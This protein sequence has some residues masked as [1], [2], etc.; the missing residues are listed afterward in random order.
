MKE[1]GP[2]LAAGMSFGES[3]CRSIT[4]P[5]G[6]KIGDQV[7]K[8]VEVYGM[9]NALFSAINNIWTKDIFKA[10]GE[11]P[12]K[13]LHWV[14]TKRNVGP[15]TLDNICHRSYWHTSPSY[16]F[17][18]PDGKNVDVSYR[19]FWNR[20]YAEEQSYILVGLNR[21]GSAASNYAV[22]KYVAQYT[23][24]AEARW[25][26]E[27]EKNPNIENYFNHVQKSFEPQLACASPIEMFF[28]GVLPK[29]LRDTLDEQQFVEV[30]RAL[31]NNGHDRQMADI[32]EGA[33]YIIKA[34]ETRGT[35]YEKAVGYREKAKAKI[36][37][38]LGC[39]L[40]NQRPLDAS[41]EKSAAEF[42]TQLA[43]A[44]PARQRN[45]PSNIGILNRLNDLLGRLQSGIAC[46]LPSQ[47]TAVNSVST[48]LEQRVED[49]DRRKLVDW[50]IGQ[51]YDFPPRGQKTPED[52]INKEPK[53]THVLNDAKTDCVPCSSKDP[54]K[55]I[56]KDGINCI[57]G[58]GRVTHIDWPKKCL[59]TPP[60][61][62]HVVNAA[63]NGC[64]PCPP[65][66]KTTTGER[67]TCKPP[68]AITLKPEDCLNK[69]PPG[70]HVL[71]ARG[72]GCDK[73]PPTHKTT[74]GERGSCKPPPPIRLK[75]EDCLNKP[76]P[77]THVLN[78]R[79]DGC[80]DCPP[81]HKTT[82]GVRGSCIPPPQNDTVPNP[83][84]P[85]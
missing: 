71:N 17:Q 8:D 25:E 44:A 62:T 66:Q 5:Q 6:T 73:C 84:R 77:G 53:G 31:G 34:N 74:T 58:G 2:M 21:A 60:P 35:D 54:K 65:G 36:M 55:P 9:T 70:T 28:N 78:A 43:C 69:P 51:I 42:M 29:T 1:G 26:K 46:M 75:P 83:F 57:P 37:E 67:G 16:L 13:V 10:M 63:G 50:I 38:I 4:V 18:T 33:I 72:D 56:T 82:T 30:I 41:F 49:K 76:P 7:I 64:D 14:V 81:N 20:T 39:E 24:L 52:C 48:M 23:N 19:D 27:S 22:S 15:S 40:P 59:D 68:S 79:E 47:C 80:D 12:A 45:D 11:D 85:K 32:L 3:Q 61:G